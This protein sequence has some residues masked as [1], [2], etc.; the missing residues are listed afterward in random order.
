VNEITSHSQ[1]SWTSTI[2][3]MPVLEYG[4]KWGPRDGLGPNRAWN[5]TFGVWRGTGDMD[6]WK[7]VH[8]SSATSNDIFSLFFVPHS[9]FFPLLL[10]CLLLS[11]PVEWSGEERRGQDAGWIMHSIASLAPKSHHLPDRPR[12]RRLPPTAYPDPHPA[13]ALNVFGRTLKNAGPTSSV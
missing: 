7:K 5:Q 8:I 1:H 2:K 6:A 4:R 3:R 13:P 11:Q 10:L 12:T 9:S